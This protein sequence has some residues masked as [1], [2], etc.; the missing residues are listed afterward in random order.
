MLKQI[1]HALTQS[2]ATL[3]TSIA[4]EQDRPSNIHNATR[5]P[6]RPR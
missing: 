2:I 3:F 5:K 6:R 4:Q 1:W